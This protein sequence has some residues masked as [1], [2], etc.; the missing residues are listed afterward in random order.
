MKLT[1]GD[2]RSSRWQGNGTSESLEGPRDGNRAPSRAHRA[3]VLSRRSQ[4]IPVFGG[5]SRA[6]EAH[7][8]RL[9]WTQPSK[10]VAMLRR[11][12]AWQ[13][14]ILVALL[15]VV[16]PVTCVASE[17][18]SL[19]L[20]GPPDKVVMTLQNP[21][22]AVVTFTWRGAPGASEYRLSVATTADLRLPLIQR[23]TS[24]S[25]LSVRGLPDGA[26]FWRVEALSG[27]VPTPSI[28]QSFTIKAGAP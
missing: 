17:S 16:V 27:A 9:D 3:S 2:R 7:P 6:C 18:T 22:R 11:R 10:E 20:L 19:S 1:S 21:A 26:Y 13:G 5:P 12:G 25:S 28:V 8:L 24:D 23:T 15:L 4:L 14:A